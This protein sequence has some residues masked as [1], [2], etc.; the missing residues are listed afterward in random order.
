MNW[1]AQVEKQPKLK[2]VF[3]I[4]LVQPCESNI[5]F[6]NIPFTINR[7]PCVDV[8]VLTPP[9][10]MC[11]HSGTDDPFLQCVDT[12]VLTHLS[13]MCR[14]P[15]TGTPSTLCRHPSTGTPCYNVQIPRYW[16]PCY[17]VQIPRYWH[18]FYNVQIPWY[19]HPL[20]QCVETL[21]GQAMSEQLN[22]EDLSG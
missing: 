14:E 18:P 1:S 9:A 12:L 5:D 10:I 11:R 7:P 21:V 15:G 8:L 4:R 13:T 3:K 20:L 17:N 22:L 6:N 2:G 16:A 19:G